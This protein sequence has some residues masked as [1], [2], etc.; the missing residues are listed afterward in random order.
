MRAIINRANEMNKKVLLC[1]NG[2]DHGNS[3]SKIGDTYY[4]ALNAMSYIWYGP[5]FEHFTYPKEIHERYPYL[6]D[7]V[8]N[9][10]DLYFFG[11]AIMEGKLVSKDT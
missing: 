11:K 6:K 4:Y 2:H 1:M 9:V 3:V 7:V 5:Q 8:S 10:K